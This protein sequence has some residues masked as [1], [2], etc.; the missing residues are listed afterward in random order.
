MATEGMQDVQI[1][2]EIVGQRTILR[3]YQR[4]FVQ[5]YHSWMVCS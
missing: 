4:Q 5:K 1:Q 2:E 3:P